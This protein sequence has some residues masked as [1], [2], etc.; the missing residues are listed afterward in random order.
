[1]SEAE[2]LEAAAPRAKKPKQMV[3][4]VTEGFHRRVAVCLFARAARPIKD[5]Q[6]HP[7]REMLARRGDDDASRQGLIIDLAHNLRQLV[8]EGRVHA[9]EGLRP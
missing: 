8:P 4:M 7:G 1:M 3:D 6:F 5:R 2:T 9:V